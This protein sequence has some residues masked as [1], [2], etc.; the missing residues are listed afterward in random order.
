MAREG[1]ARMSMDDLAAEAGVTKPTVYLRYP[2]G[3]AEVATAALARL[4]ERGN[5]RETGE[6]RA[7]L[8]LHLERLRRG[9]ARPFGMAMLGTVLAEEH[10]TPELLRLFRVNVVQPRRSM[11]RSVL[12]RALERGEIRSDADLETAVNQL[13]GSYYASYLA[14]G[15]PG[16]TWSAATVDAV[17]AGLHP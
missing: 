17:L 7:D 2:G 9:L 4:R 11:I 8:V 14:S 12:E 16:R 15:P 6:T 3:K 5:V 1:Y 10:H 13:V